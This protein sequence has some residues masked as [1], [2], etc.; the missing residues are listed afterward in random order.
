MKKRF[1]ILTL[2]LALLVTP[3]AVLASNIDN[4]DYYAVIQISNNSTA[5]TNVATTA[6]ISTTNLINGNYLNAS[7]NNCVIRTSSGADIQFMPGYTPDGNPWCFWVPSI[8][9]YGY[10]SDIL[11]T[12]N[13][14]GGLIRYF[15]GAGGMTTPDN[16]ADLELGDNF[17]I[18]QTGWVNT[19]NGTSK[20]LVYKQDAFRTYVSETVSENITSAILSTQW[21]TPTGHTDYGAWLTEANAYDDNTGTSAILSSI[22]NGG[23][24]AFL[25]LTHT[26]MSISGIRY[27][28]GG[29]GDIEAG[30]I[31]VDIYYGGSWHGVYEGTFTNDA[32][33][34][35]LISTAYGVTEVR[36]RFK[37][38]GGGSGDTAHIFEVDFQESIEDVSVTATGVSSGNH[39][40]KTTIELETE[41]FYPDAH[42]E[43]TSVDG[44]IKE[45]T[46]DQT[47]A[48]IVAAGGDGAN[49][50]LANFYLC[51]I[52]ADGTSPLWRGL[53]RGILLFDTS[54]LHDSA[55]I[56]SVTLS[57]YG[58]TKLDDLNITPNINIYSSNPASDTALIA[59][60][61]DTLGTTALCDTPITYNNWS[62]TGYNEF[63]L[64]AAG[65]ATVNV[66]GITKLGTRNANYDVAEEVGGGSAPAWMAGQKESYLRGYSSDQ[67]AG[68]KPKLEVT[69]WA[70][71]IYID[72]V[73]QDSAVLTTG[74]PNNSENWTFV[75]NYSML[76]MDYQ[77][78]WVDGILKQ[79]IEWEYGNVFT[80]LSPNTNDATPTFR[81]ASS[82][83]DVTAEM[84]SFMP[85]EE[86]KAP[87]YVL[88]EGPDFI[89]PGITGNVTGTFTTTP[90][91][92]AGTFPLAT[93]IVA[94]ANATDTPPQLPLLIIAAFVILA[95]SLSFSA[96]TRL[97]GSGSILVKVL[98]IA[99][100]MGIFIA[101]GNFAID[102]WMLI[103][104]LI[105]GIA[106]A[107]ASKQV[108]WA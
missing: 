15:P 9:D 45:E 99:G 74:V 93:V 7:A 53:Y 70:L 107:F 1:L 57:I 34:E 11:Y 24:S 106:L 6:N 69:Y 75:E 94:I 80:D 56:T 2:L 87:D 103:T 68:Y 85:V 108:G 91:T 51:Y 52:R 43:T 64:N 65:L 12:A 50:D 76:W 23:Y 102:F 13:S 81:T 86:A 63:D 78:I 60:D 59:G 42:A 35:R 32:W 49:D 90:G 19:D 3:V 5:T 98:L 4:A 96:I 41:V 95:C 100:L 26:S 8:G 84:I 10:Q 55:N 97:Y 89:D 58:Y 71:K 48:N 31:D 83:A 61:F 22:P 73:E 17:T 77:K 82:D 66:T 30:D 47:W 20:N 33:E 40:V 38:S 92:S 18:E 25:G 54:T 72:G 88:E 21:T 44:Y 16:N 37:D 29:D 28:C 62:I 104:F 67:G 27:F 39:T 14:S 79:H 46:V 105:I 101:L 36:I